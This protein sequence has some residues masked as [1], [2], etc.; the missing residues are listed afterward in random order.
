MS[1][2]RNE[3]R[4]HNTKVRLGKVKVKA[5]LSS[6]LTKYYAMNTYPMLN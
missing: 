4:N 5:K 2:H 6:G 3:G 1:R